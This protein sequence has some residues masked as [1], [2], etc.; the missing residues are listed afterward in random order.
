PVYEW[1]GFTS[2]SLSLIPFALAFLYSVTAFFHAKFS[3]KAVR[4]EEEKLLLQKRKNKGSILDVS[5]DVRFTAGRALLNFERY[6]P[7]VVTVIAFLFMVLSLIYF[8][9][10]ALFNATEG[11]KLSSGLPKQPMTLAFVCAL[12]LAFCMLGGIFLSGQSHVV[13]FR[14][15]RPV[16]AWLMAGGAIF[17]LSLISALLVQAGKAHVDGIFSKIVFFILLLLAAELVVNFI[18]EFYRPRAKVEVRPEYE[19][20][21]LAFFTEPGGVMRNLADSLDYQFGFKVSKTWIYGFVARA[22]LPAL[23]VWAFLFWISTIVVE[24]RTGELALRSV[25]GAVTNRNAPLK[26]GV[27][28]KLPYPLEKIVTVNVETVNEVFVGAKFEKDGKEIKPGLLLWTSEHGKKSDKGYLVANESAPAAKGKA[29]AGEMAK[30]VSILEVT[31]P[32]N[33]KVKKGKLYEFVYNFGDTRKLI[34]DVSTQEATRYFAST[35]F[36]KDLSS[37][38]VSIMGELSKRIQKALDKLDAGVEIVNVNMNDAHPPVKDVVP[39]FQD[40]LAAKE[41]AKKTIYAAEG[42]AVKTIAEGEI[43]SLRIVSS[44]QADSFGVRTEAEADAFRFGRQLAAY[45]QQPQLFQL[46]TYLDFLEN[47]CRELRKLIIS[48]GIPSQIYELNLEE[49]ARLDLLNSGE[50]SKFGK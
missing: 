31:L 43:E 35:D 6:V 48:A 3:E 19:S 32:V 40:V 10:G 13:E 39:S 16:G 37:A 33:Y 36:M 4:D 41:E 38:R 2:Y 17:I 24:V 11:I 49:T 46:R 14:W 27:Y 22:L 7:A 23:L 34:A 18:S 20:H 8:W 12:S 9:R 50:V 42:V 25:F 30:A 21:L 26:P 28:F 15:L 45:R 44:A 1:S 47:D 5:E 29:D